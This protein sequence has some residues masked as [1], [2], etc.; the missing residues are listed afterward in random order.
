MVFDEGGLILELCRVTVGTWNVAGRVPSDDLEIDDWI[1][2]QE[3]ADV[4]I[5]G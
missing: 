2:M 1:C 3:A 4:Y 5:L